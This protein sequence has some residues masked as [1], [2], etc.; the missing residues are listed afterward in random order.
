LVDHCFCVDIVNVR[1]T[2]VVHGA[3]VEEGSI[4]PIAA[5]VALATVTEAIVD[6]AIE[7]DLRSPVAVVKRVSAIIPAPVAGGPKQ[8]SF[9][10]FYPRARHPV[11]AFVAVGPIARR[12]DVALSRNNR[13]RVDGESGGSN[14]DGKADADLR[15]SRSRQ[16]RQEEDHY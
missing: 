13:L 4:I 11:I 15:E 14:V 2:D 7:T 5:L 8:A 1:D 6:A 10:R 12:P 3:V 16:S 9:G